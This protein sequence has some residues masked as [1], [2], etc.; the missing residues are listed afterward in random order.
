MTTTTLPVLTRRIV[1][2]FPLGA[3]QVT[4]LRLAAS[5]SFEIC[6][7]RPFSQT[8]QLYRKKQKASPSPPSRGTANSSKDAS[9]NTSTS[10]TTT[11]SSSS[12]T[13]ADPNRPVPDPTTP[14]E[15]ADLIYGFDKADKQHTEALKALRSGARFNPEAIGAIP[16]VPD[17]KTAEAFPLRELATVAPLGGRR[18]SILAFEAASVKPIM[19]AIQNSDAFN[20]QPQR[21][22]DNE[23]ELVITVEPERAD[24]LAKRAKDVCQAWRNGIRAESHKRDTLAKK[25]RADGLILADDLRMVKDKV[26]KAQDDRMKVIAQ[27][28]KEALHQIAA[29]AG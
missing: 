17:R 19:S 15:L 6:R 10:T 23:L 29:R 20:Q 7:A 8:A 11:S 27:A 3:P 24:A 12:S 9:T 16:V 18:W 25:W 5:S 22:D 13:P 14:L 2:C 4:R 26:Q 28:E 21:S 1:A